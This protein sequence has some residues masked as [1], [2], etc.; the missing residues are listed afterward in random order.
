[1]LELMRVGGSVRYT[2]KANEK[3]IVRIRK[4]NSLLG[5]CCKVSVRFFWY[6]EKVRALV[7]V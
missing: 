7:A 1:M 3:G 2:E 6:R 5:S 4:K